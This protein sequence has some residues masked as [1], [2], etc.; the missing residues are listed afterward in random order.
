MSPR[1][2]VGTDPLAD[3][4]LDT[5]FLG[6]FP[7]QRACVGLPRLD[8]PAGQFPL[9]GQFRRAAPAR[10]EH[11]SVAMTAAATTTT[12][13]RAAS[14]TMPSS[15]PP[16]QRAPGGAAPGSAARAPPRPQR[17]R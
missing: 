16:G 13:S 12:G 14:A 9:P 7:G 15:S 6:E 4:D 3:G 5:Q 8:L 10:G 17:R 1:S 2:T 11:P